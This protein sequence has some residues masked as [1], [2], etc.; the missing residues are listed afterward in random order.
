[1][2]DDDDEEDKNESQSS[3]SS[4]S[5]GH[6]EQVSANGSGLHDEPAAER[7]DAATQKLSMTTMWEAAMWIDESDVMIQFGPNI[8][9]PTIS[10]QKT[11][12][13]DKSSS[14][15]SSST[16]SP[17]H[18][19]DSLSFVSSVRSGGRLSGLENGGRQKT[20]TTTTSTT[21]DDKKETPSSRTNDTLATLAFAAAISPRHN[22]DVRL[23]ASVI[24]N[25]Q[26]KER[27]LQQIK[28]MND[29]AERMV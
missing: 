27:A 29:Q 19:R 12:N 17:P 1:M 23:L 8:L 16:S 25:L 28:F 7:E 2:R 15:T 6:Q 24:T 5:N 13:K 18:A 9:F 21:A 20:T 14:S 10:T 26:A 3:A 4:S 22:G 11:S